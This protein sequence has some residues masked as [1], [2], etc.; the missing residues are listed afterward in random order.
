MWVEINVLSQKM[1]EKMS[2]H[3]W[4]SCRLSCH[5]NVVCPVTVGRV[6]GCP[7]TEMSFVLSQK[8]RLSCHRNVG[9]PVTVGRVVGCPVT[10]MSFVLSQKMLEKMSCHDDA[11]R[12]LVLS[13]RRRCT[14]ACPVTVVQS[15][16]IFEIMS[17]HG[18]EATSPVTGLQE[19]GGLR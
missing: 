5:R 1:L 3:G 19:R 10:E 2:C 18:W 14:R 6:V 11:V 12:G 16:K 17:S 15:Q 9:C 13:R 4:E 7:V 8:C